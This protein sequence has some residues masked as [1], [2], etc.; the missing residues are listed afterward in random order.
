[1]ALSDFFP[2]AFRKEFSER[3]LL[4][5]GVV[6]RTHVTDTHPPK[7]KFFVVLGA[8]KDKIVFGFLLINS[9]IN[10]HIFRDPQIRSWHI[11]IKAAD[12]GFLSHDS[13]VDCTQF[14][15]KDCLSL[16]E[17]IS[18]SP[19]IVVG[20]LSE[21]DFEAVRNAFKSTSTIA[22]NDKRRFGLA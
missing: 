5:R 19:S 17:K 7:I 1:M 22:A 10:P 2:D 13:F 16:L 8:T 18:D 4:E 6:I 15:E 11:P 14:F 12:Y 3:V 20:K 9:Q 21:T